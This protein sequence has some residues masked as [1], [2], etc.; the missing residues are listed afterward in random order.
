MRGANDV[1][2]DLEIA[3]QELDGKI[4]VR[5]D[6]SNFCRSKNDNV[7]FFLWRK[8]PRPP[9]RIR[10]IELGAIAFHQIGETI[11]LKSAHQRATNQSAMAGDENFVRFVP[12]QSYA[13]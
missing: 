3:E 2:L 4:V 10:E 7:R 13:V 6:S 9:A 8:N 11:R 12:S 5:L 1:V